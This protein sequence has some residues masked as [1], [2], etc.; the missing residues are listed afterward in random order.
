M[1]CINP[2][3]PPAHPGNRADDDAEAAFDQTPTRSSV[4]LIGQE[5]EGHCCL[6]VIER[7]R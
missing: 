4:S 1:A 7:D 3:K 5:G 2:A 6:L